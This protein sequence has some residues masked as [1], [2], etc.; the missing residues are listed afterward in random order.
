MYLLEFVLVEG[1]YSVK[2]AF[3]LMMLV[4]ILVNPVTE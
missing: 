1:Q 3:H 4:I 2:V